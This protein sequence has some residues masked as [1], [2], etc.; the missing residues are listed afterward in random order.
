[1]WPIPQFLVDLVKFNEEILNGN[2]IFCAVV[3]ADSL[4]LR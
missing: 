2:L 3:V 4:R 1:M